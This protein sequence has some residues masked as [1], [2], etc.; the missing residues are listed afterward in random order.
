MRKEKKQDSVVIGK[1]SEECQILLLCQC[2]R[3][4]IEMRMTGKEASHFNLSLAGDGAASDF[5]NPRILVSVYY[6]L[7]LLADRSSFLS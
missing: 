5:A 2:G 4:L 7:F 3:K 6:F 1:S